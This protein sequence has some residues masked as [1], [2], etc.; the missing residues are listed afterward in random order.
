MWTPEQLDTI[1]WVAFLTMQPCAAWCG[2]A[3]RDVLWNTA[4]Q[5]DHV[6]VKGGVDV[7]VDV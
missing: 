2:R 1:L 6:S 5:A 3:A 7:S 4:P